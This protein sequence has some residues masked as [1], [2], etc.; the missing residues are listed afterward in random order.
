MNHP[1]FFPIILVF[2][3]FGASVVF[4]KFLASTMANF[5]VVDA[6]GIRR[7]HKRPTPRGGGVGFVVIFIALLTGSEHY[8]YGTTQNSIELIKIFA[9]LALVSFWDDVSEI[10]VL[11]RLFVHV[12]C[13]LLA[14]MWLIRP[15]H[16]L[17]EEFGSVADLVLGS[18]ALVAFL[19]IYNFLDGIDG[20]TAAETIHLSMVIL[21]LC[22][23]GY[24]NIPN[25]S[26]LILIASI[27]MGWALGFII[28]N[29]QPA[30]I[31]I[32][33]VGSIS[34][35]FL[36]GYCLLKIACVDFNFFLASFIS[37]LYYL[38][39]GGITLLVRLLKGEKIWQPHLQHFFQK[40]VKRGLSHE[41]VVKRIAG[42]NLV[43]MLL[44]VGVLFYPMISLSL[45][46]IVTA[47][48]MMRML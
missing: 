36:L 14:V 27:I 42:C 30:S 21:I 44:S 4:T 32:G 1:I 3:A 8:L 13:S 28:F 12:L 45:A 38:G 37:V 26:T 47:I 43:L 24:D 9:P 18:F 2:T 20:I 17:P 25:V 39:D 10:P 11:F 22:Y 15:N 16:L 6:P 35:G 19:N 48:T 41:Q 34:I 31:F 5:G 46:I 23:L 33:D 7:A 29:W 40:A